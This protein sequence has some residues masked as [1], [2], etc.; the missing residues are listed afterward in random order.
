MC[1]CVCVC[2]CAC[3]R[4]CVCVCACTC[5]CACVRAYACVFNDLMA[6]ANM[7]FV[8]LVSGNYFEIQSLVLLEVQVFHRG[9]VTLPCNLTR[10]LLSLYSSTIVCEL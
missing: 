9:R 3:V 5:V 2:V 7:Y 4:A 6:F 8:N 10:G 1:V